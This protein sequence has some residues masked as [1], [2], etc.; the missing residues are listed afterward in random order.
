MVPTLDL[1]LENTDPAVN[2]ESMPRIRYG[3]AIVLVL[4]LAGA[5]LGQFGRG[6]GRFGGF[7]CYFQNDPPDTEFIFARWQYG[8]GGGGWAHDYPDAEEHLNQV[9]SEATILDVD[10]MS[11][12]I[13]QIGS[14]EIFDYPFGYI[15]EPG[16]M[17]LT[18]LEVENFR[19]YVDRG[20]MVML[21][22]FNGP[23]HFAIMEANLRRVFPERELVLLNNGHHILHTFY[24][25]DS[26]YIESPY[27]VGEDAVFYGIENEA[28]D[29][30]VIICH[31]NDVGD[32][33]E[34]IDRAAYPLRPSTEA[35]RLGINIVLYAMTH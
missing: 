7:N 24:D 18:D 32:F 20:G 1:L 14:E 10:Q 31:N 9:M 4:L 16:Q 8:G 21:D 22:D 15:S 17:W 5:A 34:L 33:W 26:L 28:G 11:Y 2:N 27:A 30:S 23:R 3:L 12:R 25:I 19:E 29:L 13:V 6:F 35:L